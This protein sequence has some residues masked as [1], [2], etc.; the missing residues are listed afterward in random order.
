MARFQ[1]GVMGDEIARKLAGDD[2]MLY[3]RNFMKISR[4]SPSFLTKSFDH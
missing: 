4:Y 1:D 3:W 2:V